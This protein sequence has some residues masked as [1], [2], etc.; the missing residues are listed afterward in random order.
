MK[1]PCKFKFRSYRLSTIRNFDF[2]FTNLKS[3]L[4]NFVNTAI[5]D[6][7]KANFFQH[8]YTD[9]FEKF[10]KGSSKNRGTGIGLAVCDEIVTRHK[11]R[12]DIRNA[13]GGGCMVVI[14]LPVSTRT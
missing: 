9:T 10:Y 13:D 5:I 6:L 7:T 2:K 11:G 8:A 12:M 14:Y 1:F 4:I 3:N